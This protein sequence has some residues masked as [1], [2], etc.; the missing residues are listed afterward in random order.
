MYLTFVKYGYVTIGIIMKTN[1]N[2]ISS[3]KL[4]ER[5]GN[6]S[7]FKKLP[8]N[9]RLTI[10]RAG[11]MRY[12]SAG[13][14]IFSEGDPCAGMF[15]LLR[16]RVH[17]C[18]TGPQGQESIIAVLEPVIMFN[19][20][21]L[22]DG[23]SNPYSAMANKNCLIWQISCESYNTLLERYTQEP[24]MHLSLG[25]LGIMA[26]RYRQLINHYAD[27]SF[28]TV[29]VRVAKLIYE[30]SEEGQHTIQRKNISIQEMAARTSTV[31]EAISRALNFLR[32]QGMI[33]TSRSEISILDGEELKRIAQIE[34]VIL[35]SL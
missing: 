7:H 32:C 14:M 9:D 27:L 10:V 24:F 22:L 12:I 15:V 20:V 5:M 16:G 30:L 17:L 28:L 31:P 2:T 23:G 29:P 19:E 1:T 4:A 25:L 34:Q 26:E 11:Q 3:E 13:S 8:L 6:V 35:R 18:K 33:A 21:A